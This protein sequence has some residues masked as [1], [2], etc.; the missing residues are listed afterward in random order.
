MG[1]PIKH[2]MN[3]TDLDH[4]HTRFY[5][6]LIVLTVAPIPPIP[7]VSSLRFQRFSSGVKPL[8]PSGRAFTSMRRPGPM[9]GHPGVQGMVVILL[10]RKDRY[11]TWNIIGCDV[12]EQERGCH[13]IIEPRTGHEDSQHQTQ[14]IDPQMPLAPFDFVPIIPA[15]RAPNL[16][17]LDRLA[18]DARGARGRLAPRCHAG[19][20]TQGL[21]DLAP[22]SVVAPL[23]KIIM[24]PIVAVG[25]HIMR[26]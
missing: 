24:G 7:C 23:T 10:I 21:H 14:R 22:G 6:A 9:L 5:T 2:K 19:T 25:Q 3:I 1:K 11:K 12:G 4:R 20:F 26:L 15:L 18:I 16:G 17:G 13:P 8:M